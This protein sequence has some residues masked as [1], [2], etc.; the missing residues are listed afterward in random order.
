MKTKPRLWLELI[1]RS[2]VFTGL[3]WILLYADPFGLGDASDKASQKAFYKTIAP[4]YPQNA[5]NDIVVILLD[6]ESVDQLYQWKVFKANEWPV[7]YGDHADIITRI[8]KYRPRAVLVDI[9]FKKRRV[10]DNSYAEFFRRIAST[11]RA[12]GHQTRL[13]FGGGSAEE[14]TDSQTPIQ[15]DLERLAD[16]TVIGWNTNQN[17]YPLQLSTPAEAGDRHVNPAYRTTAA[18]DLYSEACLSE[19]LPL[20]GCSQSVLEAPTQEPLSVRWGFYPPR[21]LYSEHAFNECHTPRGV[22]SEFFVNL[23]EGLLKDLVDFTEQ[24]KC[25]FHQSL[26]ASQF[27]HI[28]KIDKDSDDKLQ[29]LLDDKIVIY[30][31][32]FQGLGDIVES[33][34]HGYVPGAFLHAMAL[35]NLMNYGDR[36][37]RSENDRS[38]F[39]SLCAWLVVSV[40][41]SFI[42]FIRDRYGYT[43]TFCV[44]EEEGFFKKL[45]RAYKDKQSEL[46]LIKRLMSVFPS[47]M[48]FFATAILIPTISLGMFLWLHY[49]PIN[50]LGFLGLSTL[51]VMMIQNQRIVKLAD[52]L[53]AVLGWISIKMSIAAQKLSSTKDT[54]PSVHEVTTNER[55]SA[56]R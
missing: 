49:E 6:S 25:T 32:R 8:L 19:K 33:P 20:R 22:L 28:D 56:D 26:T 46:G 29:K 3:G 16:L 44:D 45:K 43:E 34:V 31:T 47:A 40:V 15:Q 35:D 41:I 36:Y 55:K 51:I 42:V 12:Y 11:Q 23:A 21:T 1:L 53:I 54:D 37:I 30:A 5:Q 9:Y 7:L 39:I 38:V 18:W 4:W 27:I 52:R 13:F 17:G 2:L 48:I 50:S 24:N 14:L 10:T